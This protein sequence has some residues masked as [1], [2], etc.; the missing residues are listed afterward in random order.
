MIKYIVLYL[1]VN[2]PILYG[3]YDSKYSYISYFMIIFGGFLY[4]IKLV[5]NNES[6]IQPIVLFAI[7]SY[8]LYILVDRYPDSLP[9]LSKFIFVSSTILLF[10]YALSDQ[11]INLVLSDTV[12]IIRRLGIDVYVES[13]K[14]I[15]SNGLATQIV[16][17]CTGIESFA[18]IGGFVSTLNPLSN[19][20]K[21]SILTLYVSVI[22]LL[23]IVRNVFISI[24]YGYQLF[25][26]SI[27]YG[28][29]GSSDPIISYYVSDHIISQ[30]LSVVVIFIV[31]VYT[32]IHISE[33][34]LINDFIK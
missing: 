15:H 17:A 25:D 6:L 31:V 10:G 29:F 14:I 32:H 5:T 11:L 19:K 13:N 4:S 30:P 3:F 7:L 26:Y 1:I 27:L 2:I 34:G 33:S 24:S 12:Y 22:Y 23:N 9:D 16:F 28:V 18:I 20:D 21:I 8:V